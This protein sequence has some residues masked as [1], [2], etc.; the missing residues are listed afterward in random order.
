MISSTPH[1]P[2]NQGAGKRALA[3]AE[4]ERERDA[5]HIQ[6]RRHGEDD[7]IPSAD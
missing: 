5:A 4:R 1:D 6:A 7:L 2:D 3:S